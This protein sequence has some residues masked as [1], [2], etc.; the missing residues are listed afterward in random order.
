MLVVVMSRMLSQLVGSAQQLFALQIEQLERASGGQGIDV[1]L[2]AEIIAD[3]H[4]HTRALGFDPEDTTGEELYYGLI[5]LAALHDSFLVKRLGG[6]NTGDVADLLPRIKHFVEIINIPKSVWVVKHSV[7]KRLL[8]TTPPKKVMKQLGYRSIDSMLKRENVDE[9][10]VGVRLIE[11]QEWQQAFVKKYSRLQPTDFET[12]DAI[13]LLL[14]GRKWGNQ[15]FAFVERKHQNITHLKELGVVALLPLPMTHLDGI[16]ITLL[17]RLLFYL[18]EVRA[19]SSYFKLQQVKPNFGSIVADT[20]SRDPARHVNMSGQ[21]L[22]WRVVHGY[23]GSKHTGQHPEF[24]EPH[25]QPEDLFFRKAEEILYKVEPA[26]QFW[27]DMDFV[28]VMRDGRPVSFNL[29]DVAVNLINGIDYSHRTYGH[30]QASL[31]NELFMRYLGT[32]TLHN[33]VK[34]QLESVGED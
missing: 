11:S 26:L 20:I 32:E 24:L 30:L 23:Y 21:H 28:G 31:W 15:A 25:I 22:H 34:S 29:M 2:T 4:M 13:V 14:D 7:V 12:R 33:Q 27:A 18:N 1:A 3:V 10:M 9:L 19:F 17:P 6:T 8:K 5:D 16:T